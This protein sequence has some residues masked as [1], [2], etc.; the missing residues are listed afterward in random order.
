MRHRAINTVAHRHPQQSITVAFV[1][2]TL[3]FFLCE[4]PFTT[5]PFPVRCY[6][7]GKS[8]RFS[9]NTEPRTNESDPS[10]RVPLSKRPPSFAIRNSRNSIS[11]GN[12]RIFIFLSQRRHPGKR[13]RREKTANEFSCENFFTR[14]TARSKGRRFFPLLAGISLICCEIARGES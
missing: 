13:S 6:L 7:P 3:V 9:I 10:L 2:S 11:D 12:R 1:V 8:S 14:R 4:N 5:V